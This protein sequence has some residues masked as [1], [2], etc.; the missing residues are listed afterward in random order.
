MRQNSTT[1]YFNNW[2]R[3]E[4]R[5]AVDSDDQVPQPG[6]WGLAAQFSGLAC[7]EKQMAECPIAF[8][9]FK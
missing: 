1:I 2:L 3:S 5:T 4:L 8:D 6:R 9:F 7:F